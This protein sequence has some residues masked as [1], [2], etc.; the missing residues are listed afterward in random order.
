LH[1]S[2]DIVAWQFLGAAPQEGDVDAACGRGEHGLVL[3]KCLAHL[4]L[5]A[6]APDSPFEMPLRNG[7]QNANAALLGTEENG[8]KGKGGERLMPRL[9]EGFH[10]LL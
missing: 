3:A 5:D 2:F 8:A 7:Y 4:P 6:I 10:A 1:T 9:E